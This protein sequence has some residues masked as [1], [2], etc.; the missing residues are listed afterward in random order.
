[1]FAAAFDAPG[2][3]QIDQSAG[4]ARAL[5]GAM[6]YRRLRLEASDGGKGVNLTP[7]YDCHDRACKILVG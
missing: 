4:R 7:P 5:E 1:M 3:E 6:E 2:L